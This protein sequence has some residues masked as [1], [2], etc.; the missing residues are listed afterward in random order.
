[1]LRYYKRWQKEIGFICWETTDVVVG[2]WEWEWLYIYWIEKQDGWW[3]GMQAYG[4]FYSYSKRVNI[5]VPQ[6]QSSK[7]FGIK[8]RIPSSSEVAYVNSKK[9]T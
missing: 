5:H 7:S 6:V 8:K 9:K 3:S 2:I 4:C 1:M